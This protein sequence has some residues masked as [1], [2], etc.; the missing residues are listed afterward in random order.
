M[1]QSGLQQGKA[2]KGSLYTRWAWQQLASQNDHHGQT[3]CSNRA[4]A[5]NINVH[6]NQPGVIQCL[7]T[8]WERIYRLNAQLASFIC[9]LSASFLL[10]WRRAPTAVLHPMSLICYVV[11]N[12]LRV[13]DSEHCRI[14]MG[15]TIGFVF[16]W[17]CVY[18]CSL[19]VFGWSY[20]VILCIYVMAFNPDSPQRTDQ[21]NMHALRAFQ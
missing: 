20:I 9:K 12:D 18:C 7:N 17:L 16:Q 11:W 2:A 6:T 8:E 19:H 5:H 1:Q 4:Y 10:A 15:I 14:I 13:V 3:V 21:S